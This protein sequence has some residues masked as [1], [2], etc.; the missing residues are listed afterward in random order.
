MKGD[1]QDPLVLVV[2]G[3]ENDQ[4]SCPM[5]DSAVSTLA[6]LINWNPGRQN[7]GSTRSTTVPAQAGSDDQVAAFSHEQEAVTLGLGSQ[8]RLSE[9]ATLPSP[10]GLLPSAA[11]VEER[12][13]QETTR[14]SAM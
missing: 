8:L 2:G 9:D 14:F 1:S 3:A 7:M 12:I 5:S 4:C 6:G 11:A 10:R 13:A